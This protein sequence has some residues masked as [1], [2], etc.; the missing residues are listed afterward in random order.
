VWFSTWSW[1][2]AMLALALLYAAFCFAVCVWGVFSKTGKG[3]LPPPSDKVK[4]NGVQS[5]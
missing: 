1:S 3:R 2:K 4:R 5:L